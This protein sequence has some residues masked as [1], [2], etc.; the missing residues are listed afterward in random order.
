MEGMVEECNGVLGTKWT[1]NDVAKIG[2]EIVK[3]ERAF[4]EAA[5][6][7]KMDDRVPEFMKYEQLPPHNVVFDVPDAV[8]DKVHNP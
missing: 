2:G 6:F 3:R 4:N 8:L 5:G 1:V 7:T